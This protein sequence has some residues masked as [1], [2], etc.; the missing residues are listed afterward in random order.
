MQNNFDE[1]INRKNTNS[2]KWDFFQDPEG[3]IPMPVADMDFRSPE[4]ILQALRD[5]TEHGVFGYSIVPEELKDV[6]QQRLE[7]LYGWKTEKEW[8]V[9][10]PGLVPAITATCRAIGD[11]G[12]GV[13][14]SIPVY[15]PFH[16][17]PG[18][19]GKKL[20]TF[21]LIEVENRWTFDFEA[22]ENAITHD[23][24][25]F[26]LCNPYNPAGT[27]F[28]HEELTK[29]VEICQKYDLVICADEIHC[30]LILNNN[31]K[32]IP[33]ASLSQEAENM[34][35]TLLAPSK[36]FNIAGLGCSVAIIPNPELRQKFNAAKDGFF[37]PLP[38]HSMV[39]AL[40][41]YRDCEDW[42]LQLIDYL[43]INH[44]YMYQELNGYKGL[45]ML[46]LEAT[47]LAWIDV[48]ETGIDDIQ[49]R[50]LAAGVRL[51]NGKIFM[52]EGFL[53]LNFACPKS[54]LVEA[55]RRIKIALK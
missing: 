9:W 5:V 53:R 27:V 55:V 26:M 24:K 54:V 18:Y 39:A 49:E 41:A 13:L 50:I 4:P 32:H 35:V 36:T 42:R 21:P 40:A 22:L 10:I 31:L 44:D 3:T 34:T 23:T 29:L 52:G 51:M 28:T 17:A 12:D 16:L 20:Q 14:T 43:K 45:K 1:V 25:L 11:V 7:R 15:H 19:V 8:Q 6:L 33:I 30:D 38:R 46:P 48:R 2:F 47:Y 37:P